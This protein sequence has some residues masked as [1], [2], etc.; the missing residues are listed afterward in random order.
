VAPESLKRIS[1]RQGFLAL[2][3]TLPIPPLLPGWHDI[4]LTALDS[5]GAHRSASVSVFVGYP[6]YVPVILR[7]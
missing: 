1:D 7:E 4:T 6:L 2:G 3:A 5:Q